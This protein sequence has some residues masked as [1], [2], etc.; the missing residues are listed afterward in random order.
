MRLLHISDLH[1]DGA[2]RDDEHLRDGKFTSYF[3]EMISVGRLEESKVDALCIT[4]DF[5]HCGDQRGYTSARKIV[6][7]LQRRLDLDQNSTF[8]CPG[9]HDFKWSGCIRELESVGA[10]QAFAETVSASPISEPALHKVPGIH[11]HQIDTATVILVIDSL[12]NSKA[13]DEPSKLD[14]SA[15]DQILST[16]SRMNL[17]ELVILSH[18]PPVIHN[19]DIGPC[20]EEKFRERHTLGDDG[21]FFQRLVR[22]I[23]S[24]LRI[25]WLAGDIHRPTFFN[26]SSNGKLWVNVAGRL[27]NKKIGGHDPSCTVL[28]FGPRIKVER[29]LIWRSEG[30]GVSGHFGSWRIES[31]N[32]IKPIPTKG[33][34]LPSVAIDDIVQAELRQEI[35]R[36][37]LLSGGRF[38]AGKNNDATLLWL[39]SDELLGNGGER[40]IL[41][42]VVLAFVEYIQSH[43]SKAN[44]VLLVGLD[45]FGSLIASLAS[46]TLGIPTVCVST[47]GDAGIGTSAGLVISNAIKRHGERNELIIIED[48]VRTGNSAVRIA[49]A[50]RESFKK[51]APALRP[52]FH[53]C[54]VVMNEEL[55]RTIENRPPALIGGKLS[56]AASAAQSLRSEF[57]SLWTC[58][59][60]IQ[61]VLVAEESWPDTSYWPETKLI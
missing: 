42:N 53:L 6:G 2:M 58:C 57:T 38:P 3:E 59:G 21:I 30:H 11:W 25:L 48:V 44:E 27:G 52:K 56:P 18:Y 43:F 34:T 16:I 41:D 29:L 20:E 26:A 32:R 39:R 35:V 50:C 45:S 28:T 54:S 36:R 47:T 40:V 4:G 24:D 9:N 1:L 33:H 13:Y 61:F 15:V 22:E 31:R 37:R 5:L 19:E 10:F 51:N 7:W 60:D 49:Q 23:S 14:S 55:V 17:S 46:P 12:H 8:L